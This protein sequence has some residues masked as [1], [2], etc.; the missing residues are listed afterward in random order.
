MKP[1]HVGVVADEL[2][3]LLGDRVDR[4][5]RVGLVG[6][7]IHVGDDPL[8]VGDRDVG[9]QELVGAQLRDRLGELDGR[10]VPELVPGVDAQLVEAGLLHRPGQRVGHRVADE[11]DA[12]R[13][14]RTPSSSRKK[15][16]YEIAADPGRRTMVSPSAMSPATAKVIA[17]R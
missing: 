5:R 17:S 16:G 1:G 7:A 2:L 10:P 11:D 12:L 13:H 9:A 6:L 4:T 3:A 8:L 14:A 15:P